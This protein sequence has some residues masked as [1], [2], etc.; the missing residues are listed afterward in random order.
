V[1]VGVELAVEVVG[2]GVGVAGHRDLLWWRWVYYSTDGGILQE[3]D[4]RFLGL[5]SLNFLFVLVH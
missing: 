3:G 2:V 5:R 4:R 1:G